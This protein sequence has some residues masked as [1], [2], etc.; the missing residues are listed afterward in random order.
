[1]G[2]LVPAHNSDT[3]ELDMYTLPWWMQ[4]LQVFALI[5]IPAVGAW[6]AFKQV[7]IAAAKLNLDLYDKRFATF[8]ATRTLLVAVLQHGDIQ[9]KDLDEFNLKVAD[10][11][12]L[13]DED[14]EK[15]LS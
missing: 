1:M 14:I 4:W 13:F 3:R 5:A 15:Y 2:W 11:I 6:L 12:F 9:Q 7:G 10:A 8:E